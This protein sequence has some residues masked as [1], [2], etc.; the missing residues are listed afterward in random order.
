MN[1]REQKALEY[2]KILRE[3]A[4]FEHS[5]SCNLVWKVGGECDCGTDEKYKE[6]DD[7]IDSFE[8]YGTPLDNAVK[9]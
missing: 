3:A 2:L 9:E 8:V 5:N 4:F 7:F 1:K 6:L